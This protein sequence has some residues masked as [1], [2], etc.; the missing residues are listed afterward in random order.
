[1]TID[2]CGQWKVRKQGDTETIPASVPGC[3]HTDLL[4][5]GK[6]DDPYY[7]DNEDRQMWIGETGWVYSRTFTVDQ[8]L[9]DCERVLLRCEGLDTLG[10]I[11]INNILIG[12]TNNQFRR[13]EFDVKPHLQA[14]ENRIE[15]CFDST[16]PFIQAEQQ[17]RYLNLTGLGHHRIDGSNR[18]RKSQ[19]NYGWDWGPMCATAGIWRPIGLI[20]FNS[21]R[22]TDIHITQDHSQKSVVSLRVALNIEKSETAAALTAKVRVFHE[23]SIVC[24]T[25]VA[26]S[27]N[28]VETTVTVENPKL[29]WPN[30][31]GEQPLY[32]VQV[33]LLKE[34]AAIDTV[35]KKIG[36][37]TLVLDR[38]DDQWGE[39]FQFV[40]NGKPFF[41][42]GANWIPADTF[43]TR[44]T[45]EHYEHLIK[46]A[47]DA[48]MNMLRVW[49][50]GIYGDDIFY[51]LCDQYGICVWQ[52][53][54]FACSAYPAFD[55]AFMENVKHEAEDQV[56]R[57]RHHPSLA[58]WC[59]NNEIEQ[60]A[61]MFVGNAEEDNM[62]LEKYKAM[63]AELPAMVR[64]RMAPMLTGYIVDGKMTWEEYYKLFDELLPGI[65]SKHDPE[66]TYWPS[67][68]HS[69][70]GDRR[71]YNNP[72]CGDAHLWNVWHGRQPFEWYRTCDHR[73]NSEFGFQSFPEPA[74]VNSYTEEE[75]RNATSYIME[76]HQRSEV[77]NDNIILYLLSWFK[78]PT[79]FDMLLWLSQIL[80]GIGMKYAVEHWRRS[81]PCGM[82]M[83]Y[84][85]INDCWPVASWSSIDY[86]GNWK[87]LHHMAREF[88]A[89]LLI[90][91]VEDTEQ[92]SVEVYVTSDLFQ[93]TS[94]VITW[95]LTDTFGETLASN[96]LDCNIVPSANQ[97]VMTLEFAD[98][99]AE[100]GKRRL[101]LWLE[102]AVDGNVVSQNMAYFIRPKHLE[103]HDPGLSVQ[104][105]KVADS[106][107][108]VTIE[109][110]HPALWVWP[111][112]PGVKAAYSH[113]FS[114]LAP[115]KPI[116]VTIQLEEEMTLETFEKTLKV[117]SLVDTWK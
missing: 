114:H 33:E 29:W 101:L 24:Q 30:D 97:K 72:T 12:K 75:D 74:V 44:I 105:R 1:M 3:I 73:F 25:E 76:W 68:P 54:M 65:V 37:R 66:R 77:G 83:L 80:Q 59:G 58:L 10:T 110:K 103:L 78:L 67:S 106:S 56:K 102:L 89:P 62:I 55:E 81:M 36:L 61:H 13:W 111:D 104:I 52:D 4:A 70:V 17:K 108:A 35:S 87:A 28:V 84:W 91:A 16:I 8:D 38:H 116:T 57:L 112:L 100:Y 39:S 86:F 27:V 47:A 88:Y 50:G 93:P 15:I 22:I 34:D 117:Q 82:G 51:D 20:A 69:P 23:D 45:K 7:R 90:S 49:G 92:G 64:E 5:S 31:L 6:I 94:G 96:Q 85:Q 95:T 63:I 18:I 32:E 99:L 71:D 79:S 98:H 9:L 11:T 53:F 115:G 107:F 46:S 113:R 21:A 26:C 43:V 109:V 40:V 2:L 48:H 14:G 41:A 42:K 60:I 19:C